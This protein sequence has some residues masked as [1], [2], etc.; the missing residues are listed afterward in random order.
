[1]RD[2]IIK[3]RIL[4]GF[5]AGAFDSWRREV[6]DRELDELYCCNGRECACGGLTVLE[7]MDFQ[8]KG[9]PQ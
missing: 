8:S 5:I 1:M 2:A 4:F 7:V 6:W 9:D 3:L